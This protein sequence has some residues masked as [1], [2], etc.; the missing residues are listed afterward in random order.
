MLCSVALVRPYISKEFIVSIIKE[1]RIG[2][3]GTMLVVNSVSCQGAS[4]ASH[5][6]LYS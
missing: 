6:Y 4:V 2:E 3:L 5:C 1:T